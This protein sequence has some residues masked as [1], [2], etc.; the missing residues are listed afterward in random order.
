[1]KN[2]IPAGNTDVAHHWSV[3]WGKQKWLWVVPLCDVSM[4]LFWVWHYFLV[5]V[6]WIV[7][8]TFL[9]QGRQ[10]SCLSLT[11]G[12]PQ[13]KWTSALGNS[14]QKGSEGLWEWRCFLGRRSYVEMEGRFHPLSTQFR[15]T[16]LQA[17][18]DA[19]KL[20]LRGD[21]RQQAAG[22]EGHKNPAHRSRVEAEGEY[23]GKSEQRRTSRNEV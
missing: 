17:W 18:K 14:G 12:C 23:E 20:W 21:G 16:D 11:T 19:S 1:M 22:A 9:Y 7:L 8:S 10:N 4:T 2:A 3:L 15:Y 5:L 6:S 13:R